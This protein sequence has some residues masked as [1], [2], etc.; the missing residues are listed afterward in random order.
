[1]SRANRKS[2]D[3][4]GVGGA[5][6]YAPESGKETAMADDQQYPAPTAPPREGVVPTPPPSY[7]AILEH[8]QHRAGPGARIA[9]TLTSSMA[10]AGT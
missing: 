7:E 1:M 9:N 10:F 3:S 5:R 2:H 8:D 6:T 4:R